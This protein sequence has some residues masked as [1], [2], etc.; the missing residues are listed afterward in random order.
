MSAKKAIFRFYEE[1]NDFLT[2]RNK[3]RE[4]IYAFYG[5]PK[6]KDAIESYGIPHTEVD[7]ILANGKS[8]DFNYKLKDNDRIAVYPKFESFDISKVTQIENAPLREIKFVLDVHL[9]KLA[10]YLRLMGFDTYYHNKLRDREIV[11]ISK[12]E[13]RIILTRDKGVL[14]YNEV[15]HGYYLRADDPGE[16]IKEIIHRFD[17]KGK[18]ALF[19]RC[20]ECNG[21]IKKV[22]KQQIESELLEKTKKYYSEF[23]QCEN[24]KR[25]YWKGSHYEKMM[26][27]IKAIND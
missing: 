6:V 10:K 20:M 8:V 16:Q 24:C 3:K 19:T 5:A 7:M 18:V 4:L 14:K 23:Y 11:E 9:G 2:T 21:Q 12:N 22:S 25:I 1:L 17:L 13:N 27:F 26:K 15:T